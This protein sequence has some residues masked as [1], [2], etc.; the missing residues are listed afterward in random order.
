MSSSSPIPLPNDLSACQALIEQL[1]M[2]I[3]EQSQQIERLK[4]KEQEQ[5]LRI[6][7]LLRLAFL[8]RRERY[9]ADPKQ[10]K[11]DFP[12]LPG[13]DDLVEGLASA[14]E[15]Q[16]QTIPEHKRRRPKRTSRNEQLPAH[17]P[18]YEV[19]AKTPE[20][21]KHCATHGPRKLIGYDLV[22]TL[23]FERPVLRVRVTK[24]PKFACENASEC[25]IS[26]PERPTGLVEGDRYA[27]SVAAEIITAKYGYHQ[28]VYRQQDYFAGSGWMAGRSTLLNILVGA[29]FVIRPLIEHFKH[30]LLADGL[31]ATD[32]TRL[33]LLVPASL[34]QVTPGD[35]KSQRIHEVLSQA[36][37][38][39]QSSITAHMWVYRGV[40]VPLNVFDFT[41][42]HHRDGPERFLSNYQG[43]LLGDCYSGYQRITLDSAGDIARAACNAHARRKVLE[44]REGYPAEASVL[45]ALYQQLYDLED[46]A[47]P[48]SVEE[49]LALRQQEAVPIWNRLGDYLESAVI[50]QLLPKSK[51]TQAVNYIHNHWDALRFYLGDPRVPID[52]NESE[53]L[54]K[55][56]ALSRKNWLFVGSIAAG[57]RAADF[58]S[59]VSSALR[60][61][62][63]VWAYVK[64]VLDQLLA[65]STDYESLRPDIWKAAHPEAIRTYREEERRDRAD[66]TQR[67]RA[68]RRARRQATR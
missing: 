59:L 40:I 31:T 16:E 62:L 51:L 13:V 48:M 60:N 18:R 66:R 12:H 24:Y 58:F 55:Q 33:T 7:E 19:E 64:D 61:D 22:E 11:L 25:G 57:E 50:K 54:M 68:A 2:T 9:L 29:A 35:A 32:D 20:D 3:E 34:P 28:P 38:E 26:S 36:I 45:L 52:N 67:R 37:K 65:G 47:K 1:A 14:V 27:T 23:E 6:S 44:G 41:V 5:E 4:E 56:V 49:R 63:D 42:S 8:K 53:Q 43:I 30:V 15:E 17:L 46:R 21:V 39:G 10:L